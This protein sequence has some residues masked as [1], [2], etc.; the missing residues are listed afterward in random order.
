MHGSE[1]AREVHRRAPAIDLHADTLM[2]SRWVGYDLHRRHEPPLPRAALGGHVDVPRLIEGGLGA[3]FFGL[4]SLPIGQRSGL[5]AVVDQQIDE[6]AS[7]CT[8]GDGRLVPAR[9]ADEIA[10]ANASGA[11][12]ALLGIEGA[13]AL[14]G[15]L[16][17]LDHFA[18]RGVR[19]LGL[20]H[21]SAN[22]ACVPAYG[23]GRDPN[24]GLSD[25][26]RAV[27]ARCEELGV[28]VD[29]AHINKKGFLEA[30]SMAARPLMVTHT[31][32]L[33][34]FDHWRNVDDEQ[35]RAVAAKG[36]CVGIIFCPQFLG[37]DGLDPVVR[38]LQ[39][40]VDV[41]GEDTPA[42]G[43]DWD[44]FIV[45]TAPLRDAA[46]LPLLTDALLADGMSERTVAKILRGNVMRVLADNP[47]PG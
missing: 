20:A 37:G 22:E 47:L 19:Y 42:L 6:L 44:G 14:E 41:C 31:G 4:V 3:Q 43:S 9:T 24:R 21:F 38:H 28:V 29:L 12:A 27:V 11:V 7:A 8:T 18:R 23:R 36:G 5:A 34:A 10:R 17:Q 16:S 45:P 32:V 40:I 2:W 1:R 35:L 26:G 30:C 33:G 25:F 46:H 15:E 39:H 13:H